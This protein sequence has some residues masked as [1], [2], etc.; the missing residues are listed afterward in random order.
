MLKNFVQE[1]EKRHIPVLNVVVRQHNAEI[2]RYDWEDVIRWNVYSVSK[3]YT[4]TALGIAMKDGLVDLEDR[5]VDYFRDQLPEDMPDAWNRVRVKHLL[6]MASGMEKPYLMDED[7]PVMPEKDWLRFCLTRPIAHEPGTHFM[8]NNADAYL[9]GRVVMKAVGTDMVSYLQPRLFDKM[10]IHLPTW[11]VDPQGYTFGSAGLM[12]TVNDLA[13]LGQLYLDGGVWNGEQIVDPRMVEF[14]R[15]AGI[16]TG[17]QNPDSAGYSGLFWKGQYNSYRADGKY[18]QLSIVLPDH[19]A[20]VAIVAFCRG[21]GN[22]LDCV[23]RHIVP[24]L[25]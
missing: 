7:R 9:V 2:A 14:V 12:L 8:Y 20:V 4:A 18:S 16:A 11:E 17:S 15:G 10:G 3:N 19:D 5:V 1:I 6:N 25:A 24:Q 13:L 21:E 22:I 23:W